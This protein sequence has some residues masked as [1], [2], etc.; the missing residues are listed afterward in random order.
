M[1]GMK[2]FTFALLALG[3]FPALVTAQAPTGVTDEPIRGL[4]IDVQGTHAGVPQ[5][6]ASAAALGTVG[7]NLP[8]RALGG[9]FAAT[10]YPV[11]VGVVTFGLGGALAIARGSAASYETRFFSAAP[12]LSFNFGH[13]HGWSYISGGISRSRL[14]IAHEGSTGGPTSQT[15]DYGGGARWFVR[16]HLAFSFDVRFYAVSPTLAEPGFPARG[17][18]TMLVVSAGISLR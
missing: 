10:W 4:A 13:R 16:E 18:A 3:A 15:I 8:G 9:R 7:P 1:R 2:P 11:R 17:R 5:D 14:T 12:Q 6:E